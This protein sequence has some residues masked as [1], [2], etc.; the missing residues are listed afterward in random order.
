MRGRGPHDREQRVRPAAAH[1]LRAV[2]GG[3]ELERLEAGLARVGDR[4]VV[5]ELEVRRVA[6]DLLVVEADAANV[7]D[8]L[9]LVGEREAGGAAVAAREEDDALVVELGR[10]RAQRGGDALRAERR[11]LLVALGEPEPLDREAALLEATEHL[12][13]DPHFQPALRLRRSHSVSFHG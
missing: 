13:R 8:A 11:E 4:Q 10:L 9:V 2:R 12:R 1:E 3:A 5:G 6:A 7:E